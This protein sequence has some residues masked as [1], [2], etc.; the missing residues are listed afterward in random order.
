MDIKE[1]G[2]SSDY[3]EDEIREHLEYFEGHIISICTAILFS[4]KLTHRILFRNLYEWAGEFRTIAIGRSDEKPCFNACPETLEAECGAALAAMYI[5]D[6]FVA[7][8][9]RHYAEL[10]FQ[11]PFREGNGRTL[12]IFFG[13]VAEAKGVVIDW[14]RLDR[15]RYEA[16][17]RHWNRHGDTGPLDVE[18]RACIV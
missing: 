16:A 7:N 11:H 15:G 1:H 12:K 13:A 9:A 5:D 3:T 6:D 17:L 18:L 8:I 10:N 2:R 4:W 14:T